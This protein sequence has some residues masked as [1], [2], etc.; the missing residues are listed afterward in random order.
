MSASRDVSIDSLFSFGGSMFVLGTMLLGSYPSM[1]KQAGNPVPAPVAILLMELLKLLVT[2][3]SLSLRSP[4]HSLCSHSLSLPSLSLPSHSLCSALPLTL[5]SLTHSALPLT[6]LSLT[7]LSLPLTV[8]SLTVLSLSHSALPLTV[9]SLLC[10]LS[11]SLC[12]LCSALQVSVE[13]LVAECGGIAASMG[14]LRAVP[15]K[16]SLVYAVPALCYAFNNVSRAPNLAS[17]HLALL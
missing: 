2:A 11:L 17:A 16:L 10:S 9:L 13:R 3:L 6:V 12:S 5:L 4:T 8:L 1:A 15:L 7:V 14:A